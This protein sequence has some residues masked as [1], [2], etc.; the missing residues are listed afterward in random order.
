MTTNAITPLAR[1]KRALWYRTI[2]IGA[3]YCLLLLWLAPSWAIFGLRG[4]LL[5]IA[6]VWSLAKSAENPAGKIQAGLSLVRMMGMAGLILF[7]GGFEVTPIAVVIGGFLSYK[8][9]LLAEYAQG[10]VSARNTP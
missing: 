4:V 8:I 6:F 7:A 3:V 10:I 1:L 2:L 5:G 9:G